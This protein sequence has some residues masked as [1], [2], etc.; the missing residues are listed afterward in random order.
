MRYTDEELMARMRVDRPEGEVDRLAVELINVP[1]IRHPGE[2]RAAEARYGVGRLAPAGIYTRL[3][4]R[5]PDVLWM[6]DTPAEMSDHLVA[7]RRVAKTRTKR[8]LIHGLGLGMVLRAV[9]SFDHVQHVDVVEYDERV[10]RL[11]APAYADGRVSIHHGNAYT[12]EWPDDARWDVVWHDIWPQL[13]SGNLEGMEM[14]RRRFADRAKWQ[15]FWARAQCVDRHYE[16]STLALLAQAT[17]D[18][19]GETLPDD[20]AATVAAIQHDRQFAELVYP[21]GA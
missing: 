7:V 2:R 6:S 12:Y 13:A 11:V 1:E 3:I 19:R 15:G 16:E 18:A 20:L 14:L 10:I 9:L 5:D 21:E 4:E 8:V 17:A